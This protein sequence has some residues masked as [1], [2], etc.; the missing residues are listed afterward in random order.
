[1]ETVLDKKEKLIYS[2]LFQSTTEYDISIQE[3]CTA[4]QRS[5]FREEMRTII[6]KGKIIITEDRIIHKEDDIMIWKLKLKR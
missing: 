4:D 1:M 6:K 2:I 3:Y 5:E